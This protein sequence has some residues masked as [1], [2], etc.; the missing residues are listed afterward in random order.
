MLWGQKPHFDFY[1]PFGI[2]TYL[3]TL[4]GLKLTG[5]TIGGFGVGQALTAMLLT[6]WAYVIG[7]K[8]LSLWPFIF[9]C[10]L[11]VLTAVGVSNLGWPTL[12]FTPAITYNR[13]CYA[14]IMLIVVESLVSSSESNSRQFGGG[15]STGL[16]LSLV[17]FT[18]ITFFLGGAVLIFL[19]MP[20]R[21]QVRARL[22]GVFAGFVALSFA[23]ALYFDLDLWPMFNDIALAA[24]AKH[25][26]M[27]SYHF[28][29]IL[30][31][32]AACIL[33]GAAVWL[34]ESDW[35]M[36][37]AGTAL[38]LMG[39]AFVITCAEPAGFPLLAAFG[40]IVVSRVRLQSHSAT[41]FLTVC[42]YVPMGVDVLNYS[43]GL[44]AASALASQRNPGCQVIQDLRLSG[45][46]VCPP[47]DGYFDFISDGVALT[48]Q[49]KNSTDTVFSLDFSNP[50][51]F[52]LGIRP[53]SGGTVN[54][55]FRATFNSNYFPAP[56]RLFGNSTMVLLPKQFSDG[57]LSGTV[58]EIYG[59]F[60]DSHYSELGSSNF[61]TVYRRK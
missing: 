26:N 30:L 50:F 33:L 58:L 51:P 31:G 53:M 27:S 22:I 57:S 14:L 43:A 10:F 48:K 60:L 61:W 16:A 11:V 39:I 36:L 45:F 2:G 28:D 40:L 42:A 6:V 35:R 24:R 54:Q 52:I 3:P 18:K 12:S 25:I 23:F 9:F 47:E 29:S 17:L 46:A 38:G 49:Y 13:H 8:R 56:E 7:R 32:A 41:M 37:L 55:Q 4:A 34:L 44:L 59:P 15:F 21:S 20:C 19:L 5:G 1:T